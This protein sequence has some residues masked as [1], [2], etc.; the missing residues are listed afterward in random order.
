MNHYNY[1]TQEL[2]N[3]RPVQPDDTMTIVDMP[4]TQLDSLNTIDV[5]QFIATKTKVQAHEW[6]K[7]NWGKRVWIIDRND[8]YKSSPS[9]PANDRMKLIEAR[10]SIANLPDKP[11]IIKYM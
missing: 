8:F 9:L 5:A 2:A 6:A 10:V 11:M 7:A 1:N 3:I 4:I